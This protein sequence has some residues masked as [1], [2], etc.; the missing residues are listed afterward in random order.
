MSKQSKTG[1]VT[2]KS[3]KVVVQ[4][5]IVTG[6]DIEGAVSD[7]VLKAALETMQHLNTGGVSGATGVEAGE[8]VTGL[9]FFNPEKPD[10]D[11]FVAELKALRQQLADL[12]AD[13][14]T[15]VEVSNAVESLDEVVD[16]TQKEQPV[17]RRVINRLRET[18]EFI[19]DAGKVLDA[20]SKAGPLIAQAIGTATVLYQAA[21]G[22]F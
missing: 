22:L 8:I 6:I 10:R 2:S 7:A 19:T 3:G 21:Q 1:S 13:P 20:A 12:G 18:I 4:G 17:T 11:S 5:K 9:R 14:D 15:P 16:E